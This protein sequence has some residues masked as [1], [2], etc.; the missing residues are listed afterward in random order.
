MTKD[1]III[2]MAAALSDTR[3][4]GYKQDLPWHIP[5]DSKWLH[6]ITTKKYNQPLLNQLDQD[7][8]NVVIMGRLSWESIPMQGIPMENRFNIVVSRNPDYNI[9]AV[10][11]FP[12]VSLSN[13]ISQALLD[14]IEKSQKTGGR[15]FVLGG[16]NVY[17]EA[18][19]LPQSTHILLT[20]VHAKEPIECDTFMPHIDPGIF[21]QASHQ[22]LEEFVQEIVPEG[23]QSHENLDYEFLL[24]VRI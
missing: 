23:I 14:G 9:H 5:A 3:G 8:H 19:I 22:E 7:W 10:D 1:N 17:E 11:K 6:R 16:E 15:I 13:S 20:I 24:Y 18:M 4:I 2:L 21:R 12:N